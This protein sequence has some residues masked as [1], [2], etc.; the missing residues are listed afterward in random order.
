MFES[1]K[2]WAVGGL[3]A[4]LVASGLLLYANHYKSEL[5]EEQQVT[6]KLS[7]ELDKATQRANGLDTVLSTYRAQSQKNAELVT[8]QQQTVSSINDRLAERL[9]LV[10][11]LERENAE[12]RNWSD[13]PLPEP[14]KRMRQRPATTGAAAY[15]EWVSPS[16]A[17]PT[18]SGGAGE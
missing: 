16:G 12:L 15:R 11:K 5:Q 2:V 1:A 14:I 6:L 8:Q 4:A 17:V 3:V 10:K 13:T 18:S 9:Q 7:G